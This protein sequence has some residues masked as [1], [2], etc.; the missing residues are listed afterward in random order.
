MLTH[1]KGAAVR[2]VLV[3]GDSECALALGSL[4]DFAIALARQSDGSGVVDIPG[5]FYLLQPPRDRPRHIL[6]QQDREPINH[7]R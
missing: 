2:E 4:E 5:R 1:K 6:G 3:E 7:A